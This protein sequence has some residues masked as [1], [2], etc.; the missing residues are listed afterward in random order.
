M[1]EPYDVVHVGAAV[2]VAGGG[3]IASVIA[4]HGTLPYR[5]AT[6]R[7]VASN[8]FGARLF[9]A[10]RLP[11]V[12]LALGRARASAKVS[13]IHVHLAGGG[14]VVREGG[15][16]RLAR[17]MGLPTVVTVHA[18]DLADAAVEQRARLAKVLHA[19]HVVHALGE[20]GAGI[21]R[22]VAGPGLCPAVVAN[23]VA[24]PACTTDAGANPPRALFAGEQ[25]IRK[26]LDVLVEAWPA[27][28]AT[29]PDA[30]L[31]VAGNK[32]DATLPSLAGLT[33]LGAV[34]HDRILGEIERC[35]VAVLPSRREAQPMF[36]LEAMAA[37]RPVVSTTIAEIP[38]T[39]VEQRGLVAPE[40]PEALAGALVSYLSDPDHATTTG[41][42]E[43]A[44]ITERHA[45]AA[46]AEAFEAVYATA[47]SSAATRT[48]RR[49]R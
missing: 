29:V 48:P 23:C 18:S 7:F 45:P 2:G 15:I 12:V 13:V 4:S 34:T 41:R 16:V 43:R 47:I 14:S 22:D 6:P 42:G 25:S 36:I 20:A 33:D 40:D 9:S 35:R 27:V 17:R 28:R 30:E 38:A 26:G 49:S 11:G 21:L 37:A 19:A 8:D 3:G 1:T 39:V 46:V 10:H 32:R 5:G 24:V 44:R 31:V